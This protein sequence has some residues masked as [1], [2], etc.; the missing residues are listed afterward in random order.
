MQMWTQCSDLKLIADSNVI[1][2]GT[3][4]CMTKTVWI[5][6]I[7][8]VDYENVSDVINILSNPH[9]VWLCVLMYMSTQYLITLWHTVVHRVN[10]VRIQLIVVLNQFYDHYLMYTH[11]VSLHGYSVSYCGTSCKKKSP[12]TFT[13]STVIIL[14]CM[15]SIHIITSQC[16]MS[17][18]IALCEHSVYI[19]SAIWLHLK[20]SNLQF[21]VV[22]SVTLWRIVWKR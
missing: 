11:C 18:I 22:L 12:I 2:C 21:T 1:F 13:V 9:T 8:T 20:K 17:H 6:C 4:C 7:H 14:W 19:A 15:Y 5:H 10:V 16:P 3:M